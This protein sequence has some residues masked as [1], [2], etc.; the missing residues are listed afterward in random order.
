MEWGF[1]PWAAS[2]TGVTD[3]DGLFRDDAGKSGATRVY[4]KQRKQPNLP[5][6]HSQNLKTRSAIKQRQEYKDTLQRRKNRSQASSASPPPP[7]EKSKYIIPGVSQMTMRQI[8]SVV[9]SAFWDRADL[10]T[11]VL[12]L[13]QAESTDRELKLAFLRQGRLVL[14]TPIESPDDMTM[15]SA[16]V[17]GI[18][19]ANGQ[20]S[21]A[22]ST[23][24]VVQAGTPVSRKAKLKFQ[25]TSLAYEL[26]KDEAKRKAY[27]EWRLW[28]SRLPPPPPEEKIEQEPQDQ[29]DSLSS[30]ST[31]STRSSTQSSTG[32]QSLKYLPSGDD[33][34]VISILKKSTTNRSRRKLRKPPKQI[35]KH[36]RKISWNEEVEELV[37][38]E[39]LPHYDPL[40]DPDPKVV[41]TYGQYHGLPD[42]YGDSAEDWFDTVDNQEVGRGFSSR[43][44]HRAQ[45][46]GKTRPKLLAQTADMGLRDHTNVNNFNSL[47]SQTVMAPMNQKTPGIVFEGFNPNDSLMVILDGPPSPEKKRDKNGDSWNG[48]PD[49][50]WN[51]NRQDQQHREGE[52]SQHHTCARSTSMSSNPMS[53]ETAVPILPKNPDIDHDHDHD[54]GGSW[55]SNSLQSSYSWNSVP[56]IER[57]D[58]CDIG[59]TVDLA[60]G[61]QATLSNYI[62]SAVED[63]KEGLQL[64]G[65]Q[66]D[67]IA[68]PETTSTSGRENKNFFF[69]ET[70]ELDA[71]MGILQ[72]EMQS[73]TKPC[74]QGNEEQLTKPCVQGNEEQALKQA[75]AERKPVQ[76]KRFFGNLFSKSS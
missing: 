30:G 46:H 26:L 58:D 32:T 17:R 59:R 57:G 75:S 8:L 49:E 38:T 67:E 22:G 1:D 37:I 55:T 28:N 69:L 48:F 76:Q 44:R 54:D 23:V 24:S 56:T 33:S 14:A 31:S 7:K 61:F 20:I 62:N 19:T 21:D 6:R 70:N 73:L 27:D 53:S 9:F 36:D 60:K 45:T 68:T 11:D 15:I 40:I 5:K 71:M 12:G 43:D 42:P 34:N 39:T 18:I 52:T 41:D 63:M 74:V 66:W 72:T 50:P 65:K 16:G 4:P 13:D 47:N 3:T 29:P 25:A 35:N 51:K 64:M 10:Y 2:P